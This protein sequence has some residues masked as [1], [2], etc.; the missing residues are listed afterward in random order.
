VRNVR[1]R[2]IITVN[3]FLAMAVG[4]GYLIYALLVHLPIDRTFLGFT[5]RRSTSPWVSF[6]IVECIVTW[7]FLSRHK[8]SPKFLRVFC[9]LLGVTGF[10]VPLV[11]NLLSQSDDRWKITADNI[12]AWYVWGS[13][14]AYALLPHNSSAERRVPLYRLD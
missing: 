3:L 13:H 14:L 1:I 9:A 12:L 2:T 11:L 4:A 8:M 10:I 6:V 5:T 7:Q